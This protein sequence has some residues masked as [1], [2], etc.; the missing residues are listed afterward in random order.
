MCF[1]YT[2]ELNE[3]MFYVRALLRDVPEFD[4]LAKCLLLQL[5]ELRARGWTLNEDTQNYYDRKLME[6]Q[7]RQV[8]KI[9]NVFD[10]R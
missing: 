5:V 7:S 2:D 1:F 9:L 10:N 8:K 3:V 6:I 4:A